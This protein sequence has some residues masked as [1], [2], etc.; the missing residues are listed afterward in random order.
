MSKGR[1]RRC[2]VGVSVAAATTLSVS[3]GSSA[4][5]QEAPKLFVAQ[6]PGCSI[7]LD[8]RGRRYRSIRVRRDDVRLGKRLKGRGLLRCESAVEC[9]PQEGCAVNPGRVFKRTP[10]ARLRGIEAGLAVA[11]LRSGN[12]YVDRLR[13]PVGAGNKGLLE[14]LKGARGSEETDRQAPPRAAFVVPGSENIPLLRH[15]FCWTTWIG[16]QEQA[17]RRCLR[18]LPPWRFFDIP[19]VI[20]GPQATLRVALGFEPNFVT[21]V[22]QGRQKVYLQQSLTPAPTVEWAIPAGIPNRSFVR[23]TAGR[24]FRGRTQ[25]WA[26]YIARLRSWP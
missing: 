24:V 4:V 8:F 13:V 12:V 22:L 9:R 25:D 17:V 7:D 21:V 18:Y 10:L 16:P 23:I 6:A 3:A 19:L 1:L 15:D 20:A 14:S 11:E 2:L 26:F 5:R